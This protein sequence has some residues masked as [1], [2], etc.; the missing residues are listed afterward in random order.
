MSSTRSG[1]IS[2][3]SRG[4]WSNFLWPYLARA[5]AAREPSRHFRG[6]IGAFCLLVHHKKQNS[7]RSVLFSQKLNHDRKKPHASSSC[8]SWE[9]AH[10]LIHWSWHQWKPLTPENRSRDTGEPRSFFSI[11]HQ[12]HIWSFNPNWCFVVYTCVSCSDSRCQRAGCF[13]CTCW[14]ESTLVGNHLNLACFS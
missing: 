9:A 7:E 12:H 6:L 8:C 10:P 4:R 5:L 13:R 2:D 1:D 3:S 11:Q 14:S